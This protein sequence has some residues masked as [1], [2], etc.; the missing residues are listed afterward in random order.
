MD[1]IQKITHITSLTFLLAMSATSAFADDACE[2][3]KTGPRYNA[4][5]IHT[6]ESRGAKKISE[7]ELRIAASES[8]ARMGQAGAARPNASARRIASAII[9]NNWGDEERQMVENYLTLIE[10][11]IKSSATLHRPYALNTEVRAVVPNAS[12]RDQV[13]SEKSPTKRGFLARLFGRSEPVAAP[14]LIAEEQIRFVDS[15]SL[16]HHLLSRP[17]NHFGSVKDAL[18]SKDILLT[19]LEALRILSAVPDGADLGV[20]IELIRKHIFTHV[21]TFSFKDYLNLLRL[22]DSPQAQMTVFREFLLNDPN[23]Q[24]SNISLAE[25][26]ENI[27][28]FPDSVV[29]PLLA[30]AQFAPLTLEQISEALTSE[31]RLTSSPWLLQK[32]YQD[33]SKNNSP[34]EQKRELA[35]KL[36]SSDPKPTLEKFVSLVGAD[37]SI[38][39]DILVRSA[40]AQE[41]LSQLEEQFLKANIHFWKSTQP[42]F[43]RR[44]ILQNLAAQLTLGEVTPTGVPTY[45]EIRDHRDQLATL[46]KTEAVVF[47]KVIA[48]TARADWFERVSF[49]AEL[50]KSVDNPAAVVPTEIQ[51]SAEL[52]SGYVL[53]Q[54]R[55]R[56]SQGVFAFELPIYAKALA[57]G[58]LSWSDRRD[59]LTQ[60]LSGH[61]DPSPILAV[62]FEN[63][64]EKSISIADI[65]SLPNSGLPLFEL[66]AYLRVVAAEHMDWQERLDIADILIGRGNANAREA[67]RSEFFRQ[68][69]NNWPPGEGEIDIRIESSSSLWL[70]EAIY[71]AELLGGTS[72]LS[73]AERIAKVQKITEK[74]DIPTRDP[75]ERAFANVALT[76]SFT[77]EEIEDCILH[78]SQLSEV[79]AELLID[80]LNRAQGPWKKRRSVFILLSE[81]TLAAKKPVLMDKFFSQLE[82]VLKLPELLEFLKEKPSLY[83]EEVVAYAQMLFPTMQSEEE[84][85]ALAQELSQMVVDADQNLVM[86]RLSRDLE[87]A[88]GPEE[89]NLRKLEK[90]VAAGMDPTDIL[91]LLLIETPE[92]VLQGLSPVNA[93]RLLRLI[94]AQES[95]P[96]NALKGRKAQK[97][98]LDIRD[99][100]RAATGGEW[101]ATELMLMGVDANMAAM[102]RILRHARPAES[103]DHELAQEMSEHLN[104][105]VDSGHLHDMTEEDVAEARKLGRKIKT[106]SVQRHLTQQSVR[107]LLNS[108][109]VRVFRT[110]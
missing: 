16:R 25:F 96:L 30:R 26:S 2:L 54:L 71:Y 19:H 6:L 33:L 80:P 70:P 75:V 46:N 90:S 48:E 107:E 58:D 64:P 14:T 52:D 34:W 21:M 69:S 98:L 49:M 85:R 23:F 20:S 89:L 40:L 88:L 60:L 55:S 5:V 50:A 39:V 18:E 92:E 65:K 47:A 76:K 94:P 37:T 97:L 31:V 62:F 79:I 57:M 77:F 82:N 68:V 45:E 67:L 8:L 84:L 106:P 78:N 42:Y 27:R 53:T 29:Q 35:N 15:E 7:V 24:M 32:I 11:M 10:S 99:G 61:G 66:K 22:F 12:S 103:F 104:S 102:Y 110:N 73:L 43:A 9:S 63:L 91:G 93:A 101:T 1:R 83:L 109:F 13:T 38:V 44:A 81:R 51:I 74:F 72:E 41:S 56:L 36:L 4:A 3:L 86:S 95:I 87:A 108:E 28:D 17:I 105:I 59:L 100:G